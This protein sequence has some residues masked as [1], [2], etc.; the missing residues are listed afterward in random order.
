MSRCARRL[1]SRLVAVACVLALLAPTPLLASPTDAEAARIELDAGLAAYERKEFAEAQAHF[2]RAHGLN[3]TPES[4]YAWAQAARG[5]GDC[6]TAVQ[7]YRRFIDEGATGDSREAAEKNEARCREILAKEPAPA[8][9]EPPATA[10][11]PAPAPVVDTPPDAPPPT[12]KTKPDAA[13]IALVSVG[14]AAVVAGAVCIGVGEAL[15]AEQSD[16]RDY[17][18]FD[19]LDGKIDGLHIAGGVTLGVGAVLAVVGAVR[20][21]LARRRDRHVWLAPRFGRSTGMLVL[22]IAPGR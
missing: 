14:S 8:I 9:V 2:E 16:T 1:A 6:A 15:R 11:A 3:P 20:L 13:G 18:R 19:E 17:D 7:L 4:L 22:G 10:V 12:R 5:A 21:G